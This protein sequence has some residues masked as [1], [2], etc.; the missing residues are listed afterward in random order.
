MLDDNTAQSYQRFI[1]AAASIGQQDGA[2]R[3]RRMLET[4]VRRA[5][6][7]LEPGQQDALYESIYDSMIEFNL[8]EE[9]RGPDKLENMI[10]AAEQHGDDEDPDHTCGDFQDYLREALALL[11]SEKVATFFADPMIVHLTS[12]AEGNS[13]KPAV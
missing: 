7:L 2:Y 10:A 5:F 13:P 8:S 9:S 4:G 3:E 12:E 6:A 1:D 11:P